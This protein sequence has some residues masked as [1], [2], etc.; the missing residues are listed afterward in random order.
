MPSHIIFIEKKSPIMKNYTLNGQQI[1]RVEQIRDLGVILD[2]KL[3][4]N[5]HREY[6]QNKAK[7]ALYL[8]QRQ[9]QYF[10]NGIIIMLYRALV[11][12]I[13]EFGSSIWFPHHKTHI[14]SIENAQRQ[15]LIFLN[16]DHLNRS[17]NNY[18]LRPYI[19]RC[20]NAKIT[21][22]RRRHINAAILF[23]HAIISGRFSSLNPRSQLVLNR[24]IR[25]L[26][27]PAFIKIQIANTDIATFSPFH[28]ACRMFN[29]AANRIQ[30]KINNTTRHYLW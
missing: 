2:K 12:S 26:R 16:G 21:T 22:L 9:S 10:D 14:N 25:T 28:N 23:I 7:A 13:L 19:E 8:V 18:V 24:G 17:R 6:I 27:N 3:S 4:F 11:R 5:S 15:M 30:E 20:K 1:E 29:C